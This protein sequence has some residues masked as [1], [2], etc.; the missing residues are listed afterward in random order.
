MPLIKME[1][2]TLQQRIEI[3]K[4]HYKNFGNE[5]LAAVSVNGLRYRTMINEFLWPEF[6]D[7]D[8]DDV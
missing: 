6:E 1:Q 3:V 2:Y 8:V 4:I 7:M 5:A